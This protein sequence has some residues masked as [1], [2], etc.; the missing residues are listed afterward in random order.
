[1]N[2]SRKEYINTWYRLEVLTN[3]LC[4]SEKGLHQIQ[5]LNQLLDLK[6]APLFIGYENLEQFIPFSKPHFLYL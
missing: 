1:M 5:L 4:T 2:G 3:K 6:L